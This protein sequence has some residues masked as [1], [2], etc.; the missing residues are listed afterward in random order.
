MSDREVQFAEAQHLTGLIFRVAERAKD[1]F[2]AA[3]A[4]CGLSL[5]LARAVLILGEPAPMHEVAGQL[6]CDP[7][8]ITNIADQLEAQALAER[9][10]GT[11]RRV[12]LLQL[13]PAGVEVRERLSAALEAGATV[14]R[15]L[16]A[17]QRADLADLLEQMLR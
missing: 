8:Y 11:D 14:T 15:A 13:T 3:V 7:S 17:A 1:D 9:A 16:N 4:D 2:A 5:T 10:T 12:K 6:A